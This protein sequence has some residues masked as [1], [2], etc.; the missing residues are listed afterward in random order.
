M[1]FNITQQGLSSKAIDKMCSFIAGYG[2]KKRL[3]LLMIPNSWLTVV[4][5]VGR[6]FDFWDN[7]KFQVGFLL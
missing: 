6:V 5:I 3:S 4:T 2:E 7:S 1:S